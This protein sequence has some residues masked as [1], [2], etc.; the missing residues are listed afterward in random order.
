MR[1]EKLP[2]GPRKDAV[3][4]EEDLKKM[5]ADTYG[6]FGWDAKGIPTEASLKAY[7]LDY[8]IPDVNTAK[9]KF[10]L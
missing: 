1:T 4:T 5:H 10:N 2:E 8:L 9:K 7:G 6:F 3:F